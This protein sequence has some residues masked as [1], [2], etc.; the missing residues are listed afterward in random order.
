VPRGHG[1]RLFEVDFEV[2]FLVEC[3]FV[4]SSRCLEGI[5]VGFLN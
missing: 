4:G 1:G 5:V 3:L 2:F